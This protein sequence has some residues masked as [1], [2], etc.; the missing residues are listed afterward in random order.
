M[1]YV[2]HLDEEKQALCKSGYLPIPQKNLQVEAFEYDSYYRRECSQ[3]RLAPHTMQRPL[4][5]GGNVNPPFSAVSA[6]PR[7]VFSCHI[8]PYFHRAFFSTEHFFKLGIAFPTG[9]CYSNLARK[10][11]CSFPGVAQLVARLTGGQEAVS[12]SL[13]TRTMSSVHNATEHSYVKEQSKDCS[14]AISMGQSA[15][16]ERLSGRSLFFIRPCRQDTQSLHPGGCPAPRSPGIPLP[17][18]NPGRR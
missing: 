3:I 15:P 1:I 10:G 6:V 17:P 2:N 14:F 7:R 8:A 4:K 9:M 11:S 12:S 13:A 5:R 18:A 16:V